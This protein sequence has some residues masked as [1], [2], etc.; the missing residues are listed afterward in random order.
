MDNKEIAFRLTELYVDHLNHQIDSGKHVESLS[1]KSIGNAYIN[2]SQLLK[3]S[4][5]SSSGD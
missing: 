2:F 1:L 5:N 4:D 3:L